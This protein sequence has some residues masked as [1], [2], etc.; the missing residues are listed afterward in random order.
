MYLTTFVRD[1][2]ICSRRWLTQRPTMGQGSGLTN[3]QFEV[4]H[5]YCKLSET[6]GSSQKRGWKK[7]KMQRCWKTTGSL[8]TQQGSCTHELT[9]I[10]ITCTGTG[11]AQA[12]LNPSMERGGGQEVPPLSPR[13]CWHCY[14]LGVGESVFS[15][16][17]ASP[18]W[19]SHAPEEN[20]TSGSNWAVQLE[21]DGS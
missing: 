12:R 21:F 11:Q 20:H 6:R 8:R 7:C 14:V 4:Y 19:V 10:V 13:S 3:V 17:V 15:G 5:V 2:S 9:V 18:W 1:A 16:C